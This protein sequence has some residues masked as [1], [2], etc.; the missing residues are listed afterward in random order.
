MAIMSKEYYSDI[1][2]VYK[3]PEDYELAGRGSAYIRIDAAAKVTGT[4]VYGNQIVKQINKR[5]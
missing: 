5:S 1:A 3:K 2:S 4:A